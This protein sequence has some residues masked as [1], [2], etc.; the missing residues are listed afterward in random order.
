MLLLVSYRIYVMNSE[1]NIAFATGQSATSSQSSPASSSKAQPTRQSLFSHFTS[2]LLPHL[3]TPPSGPAIILTGGM[4]D[5]S[6]IAS[7]LR[8]RACDLAGIGRPAC[9][10]PHIPNKIILNNQVEEE[11]TSL[12]SGEDIPGSGFFKWL[13]GGSPGKS[14]KITNKDDHGSSETTDPY[15]TS[16]PNTSASSKSQQGV[17][18]VGAS[19]SILWHEM[20]LCRLGRG[21]KP[22]IKMNWLVG[23]FVE[24]IWYGLLGGGP[25]AWFSR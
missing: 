4:H 25:L 11:Q 14:A 3:P 20:Q 5:R 18:L 19:I 13:A 24:F 21:V 15:E 10:E 6:L 9:L 22:D 2:A 12:V 1:L 7:S 8:N 17:P 16:S 23:L